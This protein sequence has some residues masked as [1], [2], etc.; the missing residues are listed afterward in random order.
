LTEGEEDI[1]SEEQLIDKLTLLIVKDRFSM[2]FFIKLNS[3]IEG[4]GIALFKTETVK[5]FRKLR[6]LSE[7]TFTP[8]RITKIRN[9]IKDVSSS[10]I[11]MGG[12]SIYSFKINFFSS[13]EKTTFDYVIC[14]ST[15]F[16]IIFGSM[17]EESLQHI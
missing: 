16:T 13:L 1:Y 7:C 8:K 12:R 11:G 17:H 10:F 4:R 9:I 6:T 5:Y 14:F 15:D 3:E 2:V